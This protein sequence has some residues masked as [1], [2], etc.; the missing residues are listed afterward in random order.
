MKKEDVIEYFGSLRE[1]AE[2]LKV[3]YQ[4]VSI[5]GEIVPIKQAVKL[6]HI[7]NKGLKLDLD[8]YK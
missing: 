4:A 8:V 5:W 6:H 2:A 7:T 1:V 3:T